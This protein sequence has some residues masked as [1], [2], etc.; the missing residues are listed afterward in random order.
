VYSKGTWLGATERGVIN[1]QLQL[2][3]ASVQPHPTEDLNTADTSCPSRT[4]F[5]HFDD[6]LALSKEFNARKPVQMRL[7]FQ[8][9]AT[10]LHQTLVI[11]TQKKLIG[12]L[13]TT[14]RRGIPSFMLTLWAPTELGAPMIR[15]L[16]KNY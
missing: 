15:C 3:Q 8:P 16:E 1:R 6:T 9:V 2:M 14:P 4:S 12:C 7:S 11:A 10:C 13:R 5:E